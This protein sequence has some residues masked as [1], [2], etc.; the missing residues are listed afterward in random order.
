[1]QAR[2]AVEAERVI[3]AQRKQNESD[4]LSMRAELRNLQ[5]SQGQ[6]TEQN[7]G[8]YEAFVDGKLNLEIY[9]TK[10][11]PLRQRLEEISKKAEFIEQCIFKAKLEHSLFV[12]KLW[13]IHRAG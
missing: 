7:R 8:L 12:D 5:V 1:M 11:A 4:V 13:K 3:E 9:I 10:K 6:I 2:C